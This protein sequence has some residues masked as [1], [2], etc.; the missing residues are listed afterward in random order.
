MTE[1]VEENNN[2]V[3]EIEEQSVQLPQQEEM[4]FAIVQGE[5]QFTLPKVLDIPP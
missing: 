5:P 3:E 4:P 1:P 2:A